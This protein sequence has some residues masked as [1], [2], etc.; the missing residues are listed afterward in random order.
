MIVSDAT[1]EILHSDGKTLIVM[2]STL[3][4]ETIV[5][6]TIEA[7]TIDFIVK[8][9]HAKDVLAIVKKILSEN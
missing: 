5:M 7:G 8:P 4:Q 2:C 9:P 3:G 1:R 6:E